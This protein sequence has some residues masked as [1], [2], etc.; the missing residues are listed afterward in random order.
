LGKE[1]PPQ[2]YPKG[3]KDE[4][5]YYSTQFNSIELNASFYKNYEPE[6]YKKWYDRTEKNF[7]FFLKFIREYRILEG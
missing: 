4:L 1:L 6:Q 2:F 7:K 3:T 5:A